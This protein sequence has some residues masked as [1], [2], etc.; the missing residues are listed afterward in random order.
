MCNFEIY[1]SH[2][3]E[4]KGN[5]QNCNNTFSLT[6]YTQNIISTGNQL[7]RQFIM[8]LILSLQSLLHFTLIAHINSD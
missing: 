5:R 1:S 7:V 3:K 2:I 8:F 4:A 6:Q